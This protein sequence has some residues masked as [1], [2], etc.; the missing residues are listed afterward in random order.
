MIAAR[1]LHNHRTNLAGNGDG[2]AEAAETD[3]TTEALALAQAAK[4]HPI[5][6]AR[7]LAIKVEARAALQTAA[8][9]ARAIESAMMV[10][11][12]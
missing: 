10:S 12:H 1:N 4:G 11:R 5:D 3:G 2:D 6:L 7:L 8:A 9:K